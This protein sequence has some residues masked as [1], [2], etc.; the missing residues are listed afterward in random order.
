MSFTYYLSLVSIIL[1]VIFVLLY[2]GFVKVFAKKNIWHPNFKYCMFI[3]L[4]AILLMAVSNFLKFSQIFFRYLQLDEYPNYINS[5]IDVLRGSFHN[6]LRYSL[7]QLIFERYYAMKYR[8]KYENEKHLLVISLLLAVFVFLSFTIRILLLANIIQ[9]LY[10]SFITS[11]TDIPMPIFFFLWILESRRL[12]RT[13]ETMK[14]SLS[15]K[16]TIKENNLLLTLLKPMIVIFIISEFATDI[17]LIFIKVFLHLFNT[18]VAS[19]LIS[20]VRDSSLITGLIVFLLKH[21]KN[22]K[23][24]IFVKPKFY[25]NTSTSQKIIQKQVET[26]EYFKR[27]T[28]AW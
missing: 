23:K 26:D 28:A 22:G 3:F 5:L 2:F 4:T 18:K 8:K 10:Y 14:S 7:F 11:L 17:N 1:E 13:N 12:A 19:I 15:Q 24:I 21:R 25:T 9:S 27:T 20:V 6:V 16:Y